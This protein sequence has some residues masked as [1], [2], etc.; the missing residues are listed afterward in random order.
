MLSLVIDITERKQVEAALTEYMEKLKRSNQELEQFAFIASHDLQEPLR[1]IILFGERLQKHPVETLDH[2]V[3]DYV[4]RMQNA[5]VRMRSMVNGL[6]ELSRVNTRGGE[7]AQIRLN[8]IVGEVVSDLEAQIHAVNGLVIVDEL[9][10]VEADEL[11]MH[12]LF[13]NLIGNAIKFHK[14]DVPPVV[15]V[16]GKIEP[17]QKPR[18]AEIQ[19]SDNGIGFEQHYAEQIFQPFQRLHGRNEYE[20]TGLGLAICKKIV[21][22]HHG[23]IE[24]HSEPGKGTT[25]SIRL[26]IQ[27]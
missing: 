21:E 9:P 8:N 6:L 22:R 27:Q 5:A 3:V 11:Q 4:Q 2:E 12:R 24:V 25:F 15:H 17:T 7:F 19:V 26:P 18:M 20:G 23:A 14:P 1:K 13:Q 10:T 16:S